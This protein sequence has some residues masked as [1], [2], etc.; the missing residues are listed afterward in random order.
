MQVSSIHRLIRV[1]K[2]IHHHIRYNST[3]Y[4][5]WQTPNINDDFANEYDR[6]S[7]NSSKH[8]DDNDWLLATATPIESTTTEYAS[9][10][11]T[12]LSTS[13]RSTTI[14]TYPIKNEPPTSTNDVE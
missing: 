4:E 8:D 11:K 1:S 5:H 3:N 10:W 12:S 9:K 2:H 6:R 7:Y 14:L 13:M